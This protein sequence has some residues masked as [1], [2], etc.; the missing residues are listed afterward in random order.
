MLAWHCVSCSPQL[1]AP[2][3]DTKGYTTLQLAPMFPFVCV[4][5]LPVLRPMPQLDHL[6]EC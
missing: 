3:P 2:G 6:I 1:L 5:C 4:P